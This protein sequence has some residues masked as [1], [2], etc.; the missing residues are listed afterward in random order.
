MHSRSNNKQHQLQTKIRR[1]MDPHT[2]NKNANRTKF[3]PVNINQRTCKTCNKTFASPGNLS[4]HNTA[5]HAPEAIKYECW[6]CGKLYCRRETTI[7]HMKKQH[8]G[9]DIIVDTKLIRKLDIFKPDPW[10]PPA[11]ALI[12]TQ[13]RL[14]IRSSNQQTETAT[15]PSQKPYRAITI[16][17]ALLAVQ[18][19]TDR[20]S[21]PATTTELINDIPFKH[22]HLG[23]IKQNRLTRRTRTRTDNS[24]HDR[25]QD[26]WNF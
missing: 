15:E 21:P 7:K 1:S 10:T 9:Q 4:R 16:E 24:R 26:L 8:P 13:Y 5:K 22:G 2:P 18:T 20:T 14:L 12:K 25:N 19:H 6:Y 11:E 23:I 17:Q 3:N